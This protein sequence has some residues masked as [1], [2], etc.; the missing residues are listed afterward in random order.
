MINHAGLFYIFILFQGSGKRTLLDVISRR[1]HG[2]TR[3]QILFD[4]SPLTLSW[5][6]QVCG[7]VTHRTDLIPSLSTEQTLYYAANLSSGEKVIY[8]ILVIHGLCF[9]AGVSCLFPADFAGLQL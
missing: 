5:F 1:A 2:A 3:G 9:D 6:Q 4:G 8:I 7:Y